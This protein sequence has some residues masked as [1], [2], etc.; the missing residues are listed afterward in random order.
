MGWV[1]DCWVF[2]VAV[3]SADETEAV[4]GFVLLLFVC[5]W[6][7]SSRVGLGSWADCWWLLVDAVAA[8]AGGQDADVVIDAMADE[9]RL[10]RVWVELDVRHVER[11]Y[12]M[13]FPKIN[14][15]VSW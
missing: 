11:A 7:D 1:V 2:V 6:E 10:E 15:A 9:A 3:H 12:A 4:G 5:W 14:V 8:T 13:Q